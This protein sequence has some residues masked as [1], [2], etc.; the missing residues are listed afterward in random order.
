MLWKT[1]FFENF[2]MGIM[3][4]C[5]P[6]HEDIKQFSMD[7]KTNKIKVE[8]NDTDTFPTEGGVGVL[9]MSPTLPKVEYNS[10]KRK[11][12]RKSN[13]NVTNK[14]TK[15]PKSKR[16]IGAKAKKCVFPKNSTLI[17]DYYPVRRSNR[18]TQSMIKQETENLVVMAIKNQTEDGLKVVDIPFKGRGVIATKPFHKGDFV[19][20]YA[21]DQISWEEARKRE[22]EYSQNPNIGCYMY[23]FSANGRNF[24][25][26]ATAESGRLGRLLNHSRRNPNCCT[27][28]VWIPSSKQLEPHLVINAK[29]DI[30]AGE[31]LTY[32]YGDRDKKSIA[33]HP[34]LK[35]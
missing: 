23:Y 14:E 9:K 2:N 22:V 5:S 21:G 32:D 3:E 10:S 6:P 30:I 8:A 29:Q 12:A 18:K 25:I 31:E 7:G 1:L 4:F 20:E 28:L 16:N 24:C 33:S 35:S 11:R 19:V 13:A 34:W 15:P 17:T 26:D 27:K